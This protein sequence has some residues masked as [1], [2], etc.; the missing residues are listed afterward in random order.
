LK[1]PEYA[2]E[3]QKLQD[4]VG[5]FD[6]DVAMRII[7]EE[8]G[9]DA[10][11]L[12]EFDPV[13]PIAS[14]SIG[15]VYRARLR[16]NNMTVAVKVQRPDARQYAAIDMFILRKIARSLRRIFKLRTD[17]VGII[18]VF[19]S[20]LFQEMNYVQEAKNCLRFKDLY[21]HIPGI[22][23]PFSYLNMTT[24][25]V[26]VMEFVDGVK[27]PWTSGSERMLTLGLQCSVL[28][29]LGTGYFHS[30]PHRGNLLQSPKGELVYLDF[31]MMAEVPAEQRY[32]LF[33]TVLGLVNKDFP[34]VINSLKK[35]DFFPPET[36]EKEVVNALTTA[37][38]DSTQEGEASTLNF[39]RL[40]A[41]INKISYKLPFRLPPFYS[42]IIRTLTILEGLALN[43]D[44]SFRLVRGAYPFIAKQ[45]L[46][47]P[48][49]QLVELLK[50]VLI[51][52]SNGKIRW[53]KL[54]QFVSIASNA[55]AAVA[56]DFSALKVAQN[57][58]D[59]IRAVTG[60]QLEGN[61][62][63]DVTMQIMNFIFSDNGN[64]LLD[65][66]VDEVVDTIDSLGLS[67]IALTS[68]MTNGFI[69]APDEKPDRQRVERFFNLL[70]MLVSSDDASE[71]EKLRHAKE[72]AHDGDSASRSR[73]TATSIVSLGGVGAALDVS[74]A[75][76]VR[77]MKKLFDL[78]SNVIK[79][80]RA[81]QLQP[82]LL[83]SAGL[84]RQVAGK[85]AEK[86]TR[87]L[88]RKVMNPGIVEATVPIIGRALDFI[89][90]PQRPSKSSKR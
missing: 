35:L 53:D 1:S 19:G 84:A 61:F 82:M 66:L 30:D 12:F 90:A 27:G 65:P 72:R 85:L 23:V 83:R 68:L 42:F 33:G 32:A 69:P 39:T 80:D 15:Q 22:Y 6:N 64:F 50:S 41:N 56:G 28:Q 67:A 36:N 26:L 54:E 44:P 10:N 74:R 16:S 73:S 49:P 55:D 75:P 52:P 14:A 62:T 17:L 4:E 18:D 77:S 45:I 21:G 25:R 38:M 87:R 37:L 11:E 8:L 76:P 5:T 47:D 88:V 34:L 60:T 51:D 43:V 81:A 89:L 58:S 59:I 40:N 2:R 79:S 86:N 13:L 9:R 78:A 63:F 46:S 31:G 57:R 20:Q 29:L 24:H 48:S 7:K 70:R 71:A 3:L